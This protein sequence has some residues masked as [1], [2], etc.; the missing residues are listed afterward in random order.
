MPLIP[1]R[2]D[3]E[4]QRRGHGETSEVV[5]D[6]Q[7]NLNRVLGF[8]GYTIDEVVND[9]RK[10]GHVANAFRIA[11]RIDRDLES[12]AWRTEASERLACYLGRRLARPRTEGDSDREGEGS[13]G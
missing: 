11:R 1:I 4:A 5:R 3:D 8:L 2:P 10:K 9:R 7:R 13:D 12:E 6:F